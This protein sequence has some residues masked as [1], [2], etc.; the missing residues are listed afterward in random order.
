MWVKGHNLLQGQERPRQDREVTLE[1][2]KNIFYISCF[3]K[4]FRQHSKGAE[5]R[6]NESNSSAALLCIQ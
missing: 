3:Q 5:N 6:I 4:Q 1:K 2:L